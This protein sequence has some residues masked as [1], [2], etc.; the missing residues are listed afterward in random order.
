[1]RNPYIPTNIR[2]A[3]QPL[4]PGQPRF[5]VIS[6]HP[7]A[8]LDS[9]TSGASFPALAQVVIQAGYTEGEGYLPIRSIDFIVD[10]NIVATTTM[11]AA[12][13]PAKS[14]TTNPL[15]SGVHT[16]SVRVTDQRG[17]TADSPSVSITVAASTTPPVQPVC[18]TPPSMLTQADVD[19]WNAAHPGCPPVSLPAVMVSSVPTWAWVAGGVALAA[20]AT[21]LVMRRKR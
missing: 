14:V 10:G 11:T 13:P 20:G 16:V 2:P 19:A 8:T 12:A 3:G 6:R 9:P 5:P 17:T 7:I 4:T 18:P 21:Y 15:T 1:M